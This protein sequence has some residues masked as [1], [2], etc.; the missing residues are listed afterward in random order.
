MIARLIISSD[1]QLIKQE[2]KKR[3]FEASVSNPHP[4]LLYFDSNAKLGIEQ[5]RAIKRYLSI[6]P[7]SLKG[8]IVCLEDASKLTDEAQNSLLKTLEELTPNS[9]FILA[10]DSD[11]YFMPTILSRCQ[12]TKF[13]AK[14][15]DET[16]PDIEKLIQMDIAGRFEYIEKAKDR[17][18]LL[19]DLTVYFRKGLP[20]N[21]RFVKKLLEAEEWAH[22]NAN[23]RAILEYLM[24]V[25]PPA[26]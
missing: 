18:K 3:L 24:L 14:I 9:L 1:R 15:P 23:I 12:I 21:S 26:K 16:N 25:C 6:K 7:H 19:A 13:G 5:A 4:D 8:K 11:A 2:I 10:A 17:Q 22:A 20:E